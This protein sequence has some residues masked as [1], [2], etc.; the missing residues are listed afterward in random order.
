MYN[1]PFRC[2]TGESWPSIM[3]DCLKTR[4]CDPKANKPNELCGSTLA[5]GY[6]VSFIFFCSFLV[7]TTIVKQQVTSNNTLSKFP[8]VE[9]IRR[10]HHGQF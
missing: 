2:A 5:Y 6:F 7:S 8:D 9:F 4:P 3:L 1:F 10:R